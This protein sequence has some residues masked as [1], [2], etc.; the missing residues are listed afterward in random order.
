ML[1]VQY[2]LGISH[3]GYFCNFVSLFTCESMKVCYYVCDVLQ[4]N[5]AQVPNFLN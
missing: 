2:L 1:T 5:Q 3:H 4:L